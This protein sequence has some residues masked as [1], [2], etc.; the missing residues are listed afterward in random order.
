MVEEKGEDYLSVV[1][2]IQFLPF[3]SLITSFPIISYN[4]LI[5]LGT[6]IEV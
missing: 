2:K 3:F 6:L 4:G 1:L 5:Y